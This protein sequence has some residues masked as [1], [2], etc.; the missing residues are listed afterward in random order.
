MPKPPPIQDPLPGTPS[1]PEPPRRDPPSER[2]PGGEPPRQD[3]PPREPP[4]EDPPPGGETPPPPPPSL[5]SPFRP[6]LV[7]SP[8]Q[9]GCGKP[10]AIG[11]G[12]LL[13]LLVAGI[14]VLMTKRFALL[15]WTIE[16]MRPEVARRLPAD[17]T[18]ED[19]K[20]LDAAFTAAAA[21]A[22]SGDLDL[23]ALQGLQ[24]EFA[25]LARSEKLTRD[26]L[27]GF[28]AKLE[29]VG[30]GATEESPARDSTEIDIGLSVEAVGTA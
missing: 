30:S 28:I 19:K 10:L 16:A 27:L 8:V 24:R 13:L 5:R 2:L 6:E 25:S 14:A 20:R 29:A 12:L 3:P 15:R 21:R 9:P 4:Q 1:A 26:Q 22:G 17:A 11:C 18:E 7:A 23:L